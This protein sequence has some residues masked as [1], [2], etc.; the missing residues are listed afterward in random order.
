MIDPNR[1]SS[2]GPLFCPSSAS[3]GEDNFAQLF[4][5]KELYRC[6][7]PLAGTVRPY[8]AVS[9]RFISSYFDG[10]LNF[11]HI[12]PAFARLPRLW[13][14]SC[15]FD[16][17]NANSPLPR[18]EYPNVSFAP[19]HIHLFCNFCKNATKFSDICVTHFVIIYKFQVPPPRDFL[20][21]CQKKHISLHFLPRRCKI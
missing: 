13:W 17:Q 11:A 5:T 9:L 18:F 20:A 14:K 10:A 7:I 8:K 6:G 16:M 21:L 12:S 15:K 3:V 2:E 1:G 4:A 19:M